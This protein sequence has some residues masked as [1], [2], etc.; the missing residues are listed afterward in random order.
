MTKGVVEPPRQRRQRAGRLS[1]VTTASGGIAL[2]IV[3]A[4]ITPG[5][6]TALEYFMRSFRILV[7]TVAVLTATLILTGLVFALALAFALVLIPESATGTNSNRNTNIRFDTAATISTPMTPATKTKNPKTNPF[8]SNTLVSVEKQNNNTSL[9]TDH[10][11]ATAKQYVQSHERDPRSNTYSSENEKSHLQHSEVVTQHPKN[12]VANSET[13]T[14][15]AL[16]SSPRQILLAQEQ[17]AAKS[18]LSYSSSTFTSTWSLTYSFPTPSSWAITRSYYARMWERTRARIH[19]CYRYRSSPSSQDWTHPPQPYN[20]RYIRFCDRLPSSLT[21]NPT[22]NTASA[23]DK[24]QQ[25]PLLPPDPHVEQPYLSWLHQDSPPPAWS[26]MISAL[27]FSSPPRRLVWALA[28]FFLVAVTTA[29]EAPVVATTS[30]KESARAVNVVAIDPLNS[31][32]DQLLTPLVAGVPPPSSPSDQISPKELTYIERLETERSQRQGSFYLELTPSDIERATEGG[33][34]GHVRYSEEPLPWEIIG[35]D[36]E[37]EDENGENG[38]DNEEFSVQDWSSP[39]GGAFRYEANRDDEEDVEEESGQDWDY[40]DN[41]D[42]GQRLRAKNQQRQRSRVVTKDPKKQAAFRAF[43]ADNDDGSSTVDGSEFGVGDVVRLELTATDP[44]S[45]QPKVEPMKKVSHDLKAEELEPMKEVSYDLK[46]EELDPQGRVEADKDPNVKENI[47][48]N[49]EPQVWNAEGVSQNGLKGM[50][51]YVEINATTDPS[52]SSLSSETTVKKDATEPESKARQVPPKLDQIDLMRHEAE[53]DWL[54]EQDLIQKAWRLKHHR[55]HFGRY[56]EHEDDHDDEEDDAEEDDEEEDYDR[57]DDEDE[58]DEEQHQDDLL[59]AK[60]VED[61]FQDHL[62]DLQHGGL[63]PLHYGPNKKTQQRPGTGRLEK[64]DQDVD[65]TV[66]PDAH[67]TQ[68]YSKIVYPTTITDPDSPLGYVAY[69]YQ[70]DRIMDFSM[71][72]WNEGNTELPDP[73]SIPVFE[74]LS[75]RDGADSDQDTGDDWE[76]IQSALDRVSQKTAVSVQDGT[77]IPTG[78]LVLTRGVYRISKPLNIRKS[79]ILLRGDPAGGS[80]IVCKW[81]PTGPQ[82]AIEINGEE[83]EMLDETR[84]PVV[85]DYTP[86]GSYFLALDPT[87]LPGTGLTV[88]DKVILSRIG[89]DRW[90]RDIGMD[91]FDSDKKRVKP[92]KKMRTQ[93]YRTIKSLNPQTGIAQLDA[94]LPISI[95]RHYGG[96]WVTKYQDNKI[97]A[98]GVQFLDLVFPKNIGRKIDDMLDEEGR[99][100][101]DYR[102]SREIFS[103]YALRI[104]QAQHLYFSHITSAFFHNF[105]STGKNVH[106]V[107]MDSIVHSYPEEMLSGQSAFQLSGQLT[108]IKNTLS[109]GSFHFFV[110]IDKVPGPNVVHRVQAINV[111]KPYQPLPL[112]FAPGDVGPHMKFC[113]G[114]L[115]DQVVT[116]GTIEIV[117]RGDMGSGQGYSGANSVVWNSRAREGILTHRATGFENFVIGSEEFEARDRMPWGSH[118]WKEHLGS[119]V[120]PGSLY[121]RQLNDRLDRLARGWLA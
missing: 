100:S 5:G 33:P 20:H 52:S 104:D 83:D 118:G 38:L 25:G 50:K 16:L 39:L 17:Q 114:I 45:L 21:V 7:L 72:G 11:K 119:E 35:V 74:N 12:H 63:H 108:L 70:G 61:M 27:S 77:V 88:G 37:D 107:T 54:N 14:D 49:I 87:F 28:L 26:S 68:P 103:N 9:D 2:A 81:E 112:D 110:D 109:Q 117:N 62:W 23:D 3:A 4:V 43:M 113:T 13:N 47:V 10:E 42:A 95:R 84:V 29:E 102:F 80:R 76:R 15:R 32:S 89:N 36:D 22:V 34:N 82:Y 59:V 105:V 67:S 71:V 40:Y 69:N 86:V 98:L 64:Q 44:S 8:H 78:A 106:H 60:S 121:I 6:A 94:P 48:E 99:G 30:P 73:R 93:M 56:Q 111:G 120:L 101:D 92:W 24:Q 55:K 57:D 46:A 116:D 51:E 58:D 90:I 115:F 31:I 75:P 91:D 19:Q 1:M 66:T 41:E 53:V 65:G 18:L 96:G 79:G 85:S 97:R